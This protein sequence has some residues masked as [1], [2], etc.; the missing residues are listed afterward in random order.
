MFIIT[1]IQHTHK[2][3]GLS[4]HSW[5]L[6]SIYHARVCNCVTV[7]Q[8]AT[9]WPKNDKSHKQDFVSYIMYWEP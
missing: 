7:A 5:M 1:K 4:V 9:W 3:V 8:E 6:V 2:N